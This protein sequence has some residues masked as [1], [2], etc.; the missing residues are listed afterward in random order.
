MNGEL[1][2]K[3]C[4][5][6]LLVISALSLSSARAATISQASAVE[7]ALEWMAGNPVMS[8]SDF[9]VASVQTFPDSGDYSVY[10]VKLSPAGYLILSSDDRLSL[11][12]SFSAESSLDLSDDPL[13]AL[14][15]MLLDYCEQKAEELADWDA[16]AVTS[17]AAT[18]ATTAED[19]LV[20]PFLETS[21]NQNNPYNLLCPDDPSGSQYYDYRVPS[22]CVPA[23]YAQ[24]MNFHRWPVSGTG[25]H[26]YTDSSGSITGTHSADFSDSYAWALMEDSYDPWNTDT[27]SSKDAVA[28]LMYELG[29]ACEANYE[30][31]GTS[32]STYTLGNQLGEYFYYESI[33]YSS[34][35]SELIDPMEADLRAGFPCVVSIPGHAIVADGLMVDDGETTY[36]INYGWGGSNNGWFA[37][38]SIP[39]GALDSGVTALRPKLMALPLT[40]AVSAV[41]GGSVELE[42]IMPKRRTNEVA[43]LDLMCL[44][45]QS[46]TW[47]SDCSEITGDNS[48]WEV[49]AAGYSGSCWYVEES[50]DNYGSASLI[51]DEIFVPDASASL[52]FRQYARLYV[53]EFTVDV[54]TDGGETYSELYEAYSDSEDR[55]YEYN[56]SSQSVSLSDY[57]GQEITLRFSVS[58]GG[59]YSGDWPGVR[60]DSLAVTSGDWYAWEPFDSDETLSVRASDEVDEALTGQ[61]VYYST[62]SNLS[63]GTYTLAAVLTDTNA[64][65]HALGSTFT[66]TVS[67]DPNDTD[68]DGLPNDWE[69]LYYGGETNANPSAICANGIN[70]ILEAYIAGLDPTDP[71][72]LFEAALTDGSALRWTATSGRVYS[73]W[74]TTNLLESFQPL[75]TN[76]FW[77]QS[78]WTDGAD[79]AERFYRVDVKLDE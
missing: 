48:G 17:S 45:Q 56:W 31:G 16:T 77:P 27:S 72:A 19:E 41:T 69:L 61:P 73:V 60:L 9:A 20:G 33:E 30:S 13:N 40:N 26:S 74:S 65:D 39:N 25:S 34:S 14:R 1:M 63:M 7:Q 28:E 11:V 47:S 5:V 50:S 32:A 64:M 46:G 78:S 58:S 29:V 76:I 35:Q 68:K 66:L 10:A 3:I 49:V 15:S 71:D 43:Q 22:G 62:L 55:I 51:L 75:E 53:A 59:Y 70:T 4:S 2:A 12:V 52:T 57:A 42:W 79:H 44:E 8:R 18:M 24:V 67:G 38:D 23:A 21:W 37:A 36:H 6:V 54:S